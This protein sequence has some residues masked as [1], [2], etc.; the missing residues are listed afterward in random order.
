MSPIERRLARFSTVC[1]LLLVGCG[2]SSDRYQGM[3]AED[4]FR[5]AESEFSEEEYDNAISALDRL[6]ASFGDWARV[7]EARLLLG[8]SYFQKEEY[9]TARSEYTRFL[10]RYPV[11]PLAP[12]AALGMCRALSALSPEP[13][14]DQAYT[15]E[16]IGT[17]RNVVI[18]YAETPQATEAAELANGLRTLLAEKDYLNADFYFRRKLY[19]SAIKYYEF[20]ARLYPETPFAPRALLGIYLSN[21]AI[22][23]ADLAEEARQQLLS[24][25]PDSEAAAEIRIDATGP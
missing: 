22:G 11:H 19:D 12:R 20:V 4:L 25:Y 15:Q 9:L 21:Q 6:L 17:C 23:Y 5:L 18:D 7:Q 3:S 8:E 14:R 16:A 1:L 24:R 2:G 10:D 13:Q